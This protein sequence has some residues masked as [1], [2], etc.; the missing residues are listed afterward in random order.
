MTDASV[1]HTRSNHS[2]VNKV[3]NIPFNQTKHE[4]PAL[5]CESV[6]VQACGGCMCACTKGSI[7][8]RGD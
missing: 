8:E 4:R 6:F 7:E 2:S 1:A 3:L 5:F